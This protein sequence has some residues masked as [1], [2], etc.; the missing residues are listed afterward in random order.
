M[1]PA[2]LTQ[3]CLTKKPGIPRAILMIL[4]KKTVVEWDFTGRL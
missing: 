1:S 4:V 3:T 2:Y